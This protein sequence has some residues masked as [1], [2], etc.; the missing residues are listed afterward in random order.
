MKT[1][2][3]LC[4]AMIAAPLAAQEQTTTSVERGD[5][6]TAIRATATAQQQ[7]QPSGE[8]RQPGTPRQPGTT[9]RPRATTTQRAPRTPVGPSA[10][11][12]AAAAGNPDVMLEVPNLRVEQILLEV[13]NLRVHLNLDAH[14]A[15]LVSLRAGVDA[16]IGRV[17]L[18]IQGVEAEAYL[19]VRL[20]NV[21]RILDRT[22]TTIDNNPQI[23]ERLL[24]TV[25]NTVGTVGGVANT[26][27]QPGGVVS[28]TVGTVGRTLENVTAPG[29]VLTQTVNSL[30]Q[31]VQ[32]TLDSTGNIVERTLNAT[33]GIVNERT[34][35]RLLDMQVIN[36]TTNAA[37]ETVRQ[38]RDTGGAVIEYVLD[39]SGRIVRSRVVS[40]GAQR[41]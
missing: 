33:G 28:Q 22:L 9:I 14:V 1:G 8:I 26:A 38:V 16:T 21:A 5:Q 6:N 15:N 17:K 31:T 7:T 23:L 3:L 4:A 12:R 19:T 18:D 25:D 35:G 39:T 27:L 13:D 29:G 24:T 2:L 37:G 40:G 32:R 20:H 10:R 34:V 30:G 11:D 41:R 36:Q